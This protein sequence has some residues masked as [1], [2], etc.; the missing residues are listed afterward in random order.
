MSYGSPSQAWFLFIRAVV[1]FS[2]EVGVGLILAY[3]IYFFLSLPLRRK[4]RARLFLDLL[5]SGI[6]QGQSPERLVTSLAA[7]KDHVFGIRFYLLAAHMEQGKSFLAALEAVPRFLPAT[8]V[9]MLKIGSELGGF[10]RVLPACRQVLEEGSNQ[11]IKAQNYLVVF[12]FTALPAAKGILAVLAVWVLPKFAEIA[13]DMEAPAPAMFLWFQRAMPMLMFINTLFTLVLLAGVAVYIGGPRVSEWLREFT[14]H[15]M[16]RLIYR[17]P[18]KRK[19]MQRDFCAMLALLLDAGVNE[20]KS[21]LLAAEA[22]GNTRFKERANRAAAMLHSGVSL[23]EAVGQ[24]DG[25]GEF[26]WRLRNATHARSN[27]S[28]ALAGWQEALGAKAFQQE[29]AVAHVVTTAFV[30]YGGLIVGITAVSVFSVLIRILENAAS[31]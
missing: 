10:E 15:A 20:E 4:E 9:G 28:Q 13:I 11:V 7:T 5:E 22:T 1:V 17:L 31:W 30:L 26:H 12:L 3:G 23:T 8:V 29:Q 19:R 14:F 27:F 25:T 6:K 24:L 18:W 21:L 2:L 16:D